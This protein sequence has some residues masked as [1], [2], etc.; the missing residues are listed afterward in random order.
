[1]RAVPRSQHADKPP[2]CVGKRAALARQLFHALLERELRELG[3]FFQ[4]PAFGRSAMG[5]E[6]RFAP[7]R[8]SARCGFRKETIAGVSRNGRDAP[9]D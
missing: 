9:K 2:N 1:M 8:L 4:Q 5:H 7:P 3:P 6:E